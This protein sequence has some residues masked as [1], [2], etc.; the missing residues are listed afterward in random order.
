MEELGIDVLD[1]VESTITPSSDTDKPII[2]TKEKTYVIK[3]HDNF[4]FLYDVTATDATDGN[5]T[6]K[7]TNNISDLDFTKEGVKKVIYSVSDNAGNITEEIVYVTV[8]KDNTSLIRLGQ[9]GLLLVLLVAI[10]FLYKYIRSLKLEKRFSKYTINSS[11][12]KSISLAD[13][14][15]VQYTDFIDKLSKKISKSKVLSFT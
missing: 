10:I 9:F 14:L 13:N 15:Y 4:D 3:A 1:E 6:N 11:K 12:N 5:I 2:Y 7:I 8:K